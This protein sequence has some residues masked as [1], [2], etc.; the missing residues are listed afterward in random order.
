MAE[1]V[2]RF[3][4]PPD[5]GDG[6][7]GGEYELVSLECENCG[8]GDFSVWFDGD[9]GRLI[10]TDCRKPQEAVFCIERGDED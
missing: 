10:C 5:Y 6:D 3:E 9:V 2:A 1:N 7:G 4:R 8:G